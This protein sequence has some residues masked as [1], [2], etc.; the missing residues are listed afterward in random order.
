MYSFSSSASDLISSGADVAST[1]GYYHHHHH[2]GNVSGYHGVVQQPPQHH[3]Q[4]VYQHS[5][6]F[7]A[8]EGARIHLHQ[9][10]QHQPA[11]T[12]FDCRSPVSA[13]SWAGSLGSPDSPRLLT[14]L[15]PGSSNNNDQQQRLVQ[16]LPTNDEYLHLSNDPADS[17][18][19]PSLT[20]DE[21]SAGEFGGSNLLWTDE[22]SAAGG[23][24]PVGKTENAPAKGPMKRQRKTRTPRAPKSN[25]S[26][27]SGSSTSRRRSSKAPT[28][29]VVK[30]RRLAAN[31]RERRRMNSLNDAFERLREVVPSLGSDRKLSKFE[32][33]QMAQTYIGAL[34]E[35]LQRHWPSLNNNMTL[36]LYNHNIATLLLSSFKTHIILSDLL[37]YFSKMKFYVINI[38]HPTFLVVFSSCCARIYIIMWRLK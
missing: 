5:T 23:P 35:L 25:G 9:T 32:T 1:H 33:L 13:Q 28:V 7:T 15:G 31:A 27:A 16:Q 24:D 19:V 21:E 20:E 36:N 17:V 37:A 14:E 2:H 8:E 4:D 26:S 12:L 6:G 22:S 11:S 18:G 3:H 29:E 38:H 30:K 34:A 10:S